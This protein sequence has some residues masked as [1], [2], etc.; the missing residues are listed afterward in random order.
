MTL[1][2]I[3][4]KQPK[5]QRIKVLYRKMNNAKLP[6]KCEQKT[7]WIKKLLKA[8]V[9]FCSILVVVYSLAVL[10]LDPNFLKRDLQDKFGQVKGVSVSLGVVVVGDPQKPIVQTEVGC[11]GE[12]PYVKLSWGQDPL[13]ASFRIIRDGEILAIGIAGTEYTDNTPT[14]GTHQYIVTA[15]GSNGTDV[16]SDLVSVVASQCAIS[17]DDEEDDTRREDPTCKIKTVDSINVS[18]FKGVLKIENQR[19]IFTGHTNLEKAK[20]RIEII[21][22]T[23]I[24][25]EIRANKNGFWQWQSPLNLANGN[26]EIRV[27]AIDPRDSARNKT[28]SLVL[29]VISGAEGMPIEEISRESLPFDFEMEV[30]NPDRVVYAGEELYLK[31]TINKLRDFAPWDGT[32]KY[33]IRDLAGNKLIETSDQINVFGNQE[34][35]KKINLSKL[36]KTEKYNISIKIS[37]KNFNI[38]SED[39]FY[40]KEKPLLRLSSGQTITLTEIFSGLSW[41]ILLLLALILIFLTLLML[42][43]RLAENAKMQITENIFRKNGFLGKEVDR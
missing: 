7:N 8:G 40:L 26:Y 9:V 2:M 12:N 30:Q 6:K 3:S 21:G 1:F 4:Y 23:G 5:G 16:S 13:A 31:I 17:I 15:V 25:A 14:S 29:R 39:E 20:I 38:F 34:I 28:D 33:E 10:S 24:F 43:H 11:S 32:L 27:K 36:L 42:E 37:Y 18:G 41:L 35:Y 19:P 22:E